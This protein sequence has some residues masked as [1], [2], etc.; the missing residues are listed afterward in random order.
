M[1]DTIKT[2]FLRAISI[3]HT[4]VLNAKLNGSHFNNI[5]SVLYNNYNIHFYTN[6][7]CSRNKKIQ[8]KNEAINVD[9][10]LTN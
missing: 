7:N 9:P 3:L 5:A 8:L 10:I 4:N 6:T 2:G 1:L